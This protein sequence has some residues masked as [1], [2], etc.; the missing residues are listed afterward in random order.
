MLWRGLLA[1]AYLGP[2]APRRRGNRR[3]V[4]RVAAGGRSN[5]PTVRA[6]D[7][8]EKPKANGPEFTRGTF[9][10]AGKAKSER[11]HETRNPS[12]SMD[13]Q[14]P[15][16]SMLPDLAPRLEE[17][18]SPRQDGPRAKKS[19]SD[20][21]TVAAL[22]DQAREVLKQRRYSGRTERAF[23]DWIG[24]FFRFVPGRELDGLGEADLR[25][26]LEDLAGTEISHRSLAQARAALLVLFHGVLGRQINCTG[27]GRAEGSALAPL[28]RSETAQLLAAVAPGYALA[29]ALTYGSGLRPTELLALRVG[30]V[31]LDVGHLRLQDFRAGRPPRTT[32]IPAALVEPLRAH[33]VALRS[34]FE[35]DLARG[36]GFA[37]LPESVRTS[38]PEAARAFEWQWLF[39]VVTRLTRNP[40]NGEGRRGHIDEVDLQRAVA[41]AARTAG[42][43]QTVDLQTLRA[44]F[45]QHLSDAGF[46]VA[47]VQSALGVQP[48]PASTSVPALLPSPL[49][50]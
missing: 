29:I 35:S 30:D 38:Q 7:C 36:A 45:A 13:A 20:Q 11:W 22:L 46:P 34:L 4:R 48:A 24:R 49:D 40:L 47:S 25:A 16:P 44:S 1:A 27:L 17:R 50:L 5:R 41:A 3:T 8:G 33:M 32:M 14:L 15:S 12:G 37:S 26:Y 10:R 23:L 6:S 18:Y 39:P 2:S 42:L 31:D 19:T 43:S 28:S 9:R 21:R